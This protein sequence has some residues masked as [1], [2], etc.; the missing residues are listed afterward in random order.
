MPDF[1]R[2]VVTAC[3][4]TLVFQKEQRKKR[5]IDD[6]VTLRHSYLM[7]RLHVCLRNIQSKNVI[8]EYKGAIHTHT[9]RGVCTLKR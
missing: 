7:Y 6:I 2:T 8:N 9:S 3:F 5:A 4:Q 1:A